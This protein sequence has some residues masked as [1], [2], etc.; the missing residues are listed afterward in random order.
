MLAVLVAAGM[1]GI[2]DESF[3][4]RVIGARLEKQASR[5]CA[6]AIDGERAARIAASAAAEGDASLAAALPAL[7]AE[8]EAQQRQQSSSGSRRRCT[9]ASASWSCRRGSPWARA[10]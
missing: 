8:S 1:G 3:D 10:R 7:L 4:L 2:I 5:V 9:W 6:R